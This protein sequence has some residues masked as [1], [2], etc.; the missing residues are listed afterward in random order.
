V[1]KAFYNTNLSSLR[2][3]NIDVPVYSSYESIVLDKIG[4]TGI[5]NFGVEIK[6]NGITG[7]VIDCSVY[8]SPNGIDWFDLQSNLFTSYIE[9]GEFR[10]VEFT[11]VTG[12]L[13][14]SV[15]SDIDTNINIHVHGNIS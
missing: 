11:V 15:Q 5:T 14:V 13:R 2:S 1:Q 12:Y 4:I 8:G 10:H 3:W 9:P 7:N 6:N